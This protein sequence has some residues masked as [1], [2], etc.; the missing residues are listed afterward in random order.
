MQIPGDEVRSQILLSGT[1]T[2]NPLNPPMIVEYKIVVN[3]VQLH[4]AK[5]QNES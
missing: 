3:V 2:E 5:S 1:G 4:N